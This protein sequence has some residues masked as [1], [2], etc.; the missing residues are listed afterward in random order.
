MK[1][2]YIKQTKIETTVEN[3]IMMMTPVMNGRTLPMPN[4]NENPFLSPAFTLTPK[5]N[6]GQVGKNEEMNVA[7][8]SLKGMMG[9]NME[10]KEKIEKLNMSTK[11]VEKLMDFEIKEKSKC[12]LHIENEKSLKQVSTNPSYSEFLRKRTLT[13]PKGEEHDAAQ[14]ALHL[15]YHNKIV[16]PKASSNTNSFTNLQK[17]EITSMDEN[18]TRFEESKANFLNNNNN[19]RSSI[20]VPKKEDGKASNIRSKLK[21]LE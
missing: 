5:I 4:N 10:K 1:T 11:K 7:L 9:M 2:S 21:Q 3:D 17:L 16:R 19:E 6:I 8:N 13:L 14:G 18:K 12:D 20:S 15:P